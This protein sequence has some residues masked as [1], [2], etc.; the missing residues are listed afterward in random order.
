MP[1]SE[2]IRRSKGKILRRIREQ[3]PRKKKSASPSTAIVKATPAPQVLSI[4]EAIEKVLILGD[5][6]GLLPQERIDYYNRVCQSLGLNPLTMPFS[7]ILFRESDAGAPKLSLYANKSCTEQLRKIHGVSVI[8]PLRRSRT[9]DIVTVEADVRDKTGR[10]DSASG[11][12]A[13]YKFKDGKRIDFTGKDLC[14]AEMKCE[15]K[16]KRRATLSICGLAFLDES[17]LDTMDIVGGVTRDGRIYYHAGEEP[18]FQHGSHEAA[19][20]VL[21]GKLAAHAEGKTI[22]AQIVTPD[23]SKPASDGE[24][25]RGNAPQSVPRAAKAPTLEFKGTVELDYSNEAWPIVRGDLSDILED[26]KATC[27]TLDWG[28]DEFY[29]VQPRDLE[30]LK[31]RCA[32]LG[33]KVTETLPKK[34]PQ[35]QEETTVVERAVGSASAA[36]AVVSGTIERVNTGMAGKNPV[37]HV[38]LLLADRTKPTYSC[39]DKKWFEALDAG[40]GK[41]ARLITKQNGKYTN[42]VGA[43]TIGSKEW[44]EDGTPVVQRDREAGGKTLF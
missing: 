43:L 1:K 4:P 32:K 21:K 41:F 36:P 29:H 23:P 22:D 8:P 15:T 42:I 33:Y 31:V 37:K 16:A 17:E 34:V 9:S 12:V 18:K 40:L 7:Y 39:F 3:T 28:K 20:E 2:K 5:L 24:A 13:L 38:T 10:T 30:A 6:S 27:P 26:L 14:N 25:G 35:K 44:L 19:Q 11:S